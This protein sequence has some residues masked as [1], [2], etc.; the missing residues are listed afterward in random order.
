MLSRYDGKKIKITTEDGK[1]FVGEAESFSSGYGLHEFGIEE[2][3][4]S[5]GNC[6]IFLSQIKSIE[7]DTCRI[8]GKGAREYSALIGELLEGDYMILDVLPSKVPA[9]SAGQ[10]FAVDRYFR[11]KERLSLLYRRFAELLLRL[12]CYYDIDVS[13]DGG[14]ICEM[15]PD[16]EEFVRSVINVSGSGFL[17]VIFPMQRSMIDLDHGDTYMTVYC[18]D[19]ELHEKIGALARSEGFHFRKP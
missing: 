3:S 16:P 11:E 2:E 5:L 17:R 13:F 15:N 12:N 1:V 4:V 7:E 19:V 8:S 14:E 9:G 10:F 6:Q 18:S